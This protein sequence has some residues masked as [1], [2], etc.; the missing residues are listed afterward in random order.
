[1][2]NLGLKLWSINRNYLHAAVKLHEEGVCDFIELSYI[3]GTTEQCARLWMSLEIPY[4]I[5]AP[6][7]YLGLNI[8]KKESRKDNF[9]L[10]KKT[11]QFADKLSAK[12]IIFHPGIDGD[13]E[14]AIYQ[15]NEID[16]SRIIIENKPYF[17]NFSVGD[18]RVCNGYSPE[19]IKLIMNETGVG[20]CLDASHAIYAANA[21][22]IDSFGYLK[23]FNELNPK[24]YHITNGDRDGTF[25]GH[26]N[27]HRGNFD[28]KAILNIFD[29][30]K[31]VT[32]ETVKNFESSLDDFRRDVLFLHDLIGQKTCN[33][34]AAQ[35]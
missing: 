1:M 21:Q 20:F 3:P 8:S 18:D 32:I 2:L 11:L 23:K 16:D 35:L 28:I 29:T 15:I 24:M 5:H 7:T 6:H 4:V 12:Q 33:S 27:F 25:D 10:A 30:T 14:E 34:Q 9:F 19:E 17:S 26:A 13:I 31:K 22:K